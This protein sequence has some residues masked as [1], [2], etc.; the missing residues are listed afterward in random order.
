[1][2]VWASCLVGCGFNGCGVCEDED[3]GCLESLRR[4]SEGE[5]LAQREDGLSARVHGGFDLSMTELSRA[6]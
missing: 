4:D 1:V 3:V 6:E 2:V 5:F